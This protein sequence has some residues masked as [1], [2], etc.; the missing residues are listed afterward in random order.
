MLRRK[1]N[2]PFQKGGMGTMR[3]IAA[4]F[5]LLLLC[6]ALCLPVAA[7]SSATMVQ[8]TA[9]LSPEGSAQMNMTVSL[10][11]DSDPG[12][13]YFPIPK[14]AQNVLLNGA[15]A[16]TQVKNGVLRIL[17][18][19]LSAGDF[20]FTFSYRLPLVTVSEGDHLLVELPLLSGFAY[21]IEA[22]E[23]TVTLPDAV[24]GRPEFSSGYHQEAI[25]GALVSTV[26][27]NT[28]SVAVVEGL[29]DHETLTMRLEADPA[30]FPQVILSEPLLSGWDG[31]A[32]VCIALAVVYYLICLL[33]VVSTRRTRCFSAPDGINAGEVGTCLTG[34]GADLTLM[35]LT[36]AQL[37]YIHMHIDKQG[38][39]SLY[40]QMDMGNERSEFENRVFRDLF[41]NRAVVA[42][43]SYHYARLCRKVATK[44]P[45]LRQLFKPSSGNPRI[46]RGLAALAGILSGVS[47]AVSVSSQ[48]GVQTLLG[49]LFALLCG[50]FS[51]CIQSGGRC[52]PLRDKQSLYIALG[53]MGAWLLLGLLTASF[54]AAALMAA[55]QFLCGIAAAYGGQRSERGKRCLAELRSLRSFLVS[56]QGSE[57]QRM[58]QGNPNYFYELAPYALAM[59]V[60]KKFARRF[61]R[62]TLPEQSFLTTEPARELTPLQL[63]SL[64]GQA[65]DSM[66]ALQKRLPYENLRFMPNPP[67]QN[68]ER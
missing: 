9:I 39:V 36:W 11:L 66:N 37:G 31:A 58:V 54:G 28:V 63:M 22:M 17:L 61:G 25:E 14:D 29:K 51:W 6:S 60:D 34:C 62:M 19:S 12:E 45:L 24:T 20:T 59:G 48:V 21:P 40:Q 32:L 50:V 1:P 35:V 7:A 2:D 55:F 27:A 47:L 43:N 13:L 18:P 53:C 23:F 49:L 3:R 52:L 26:Q 44:S 5:A 57:L 41:R 15:Q 42:G 38:R 16:S 64:L 30:M 8:S 68:R 65:M 33:P 46:F 10:H 4:I 56:T 67:A